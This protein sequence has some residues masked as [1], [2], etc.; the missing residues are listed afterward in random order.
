MIIGFSTGVVHKQMNTKEATNLIRSIG[1]NAVE[2]G[3]VRKQ[4]IGD[5]WM[6]M[7]TAEDLNGFDFVSV[8][9]PSDLEYKKDRQTSDVLDGL[10]K[11]NKIRPLDLV[12]FHPQ[13]EMDLSLFTNLPYPVSFENMDHRKDFGKDLKDLKKVFSFSK[14]FKMTLDLNHVF[15]NDT[16]M[17]LADEFYKEFGDRIAE[18]HLS[19][20]E[21]LHEPLYKT[22]QLEIINKV[23]SNIPIIVESVMDQIE[24][25]NEKDYILN[26]I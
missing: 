2:L 6:N 13:K 21:K 23:K 14:Q 8:H 12:V 5:G 19:G 17:K 3:F 18:I 7:L 16:T 11:L 20:F 10:K 22:K 1:C 9:A 15:T 4:R 25:K 24:I 26:N